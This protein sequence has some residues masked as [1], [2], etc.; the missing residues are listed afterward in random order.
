VCDCIEGCECG[1]G[2]SVRGVSVKY[3]VIH[4][5]LLSKSHSSKAI[6]MLSL[7]PELLTPTANLG[8]LL[9]LPLLPPPAPAPAHH[10]EVMGSC[11]PSAG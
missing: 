5:Y 2:V 8:S 7:N 10:I 3:R 4:S 9:L 11:C 1:V 6:L